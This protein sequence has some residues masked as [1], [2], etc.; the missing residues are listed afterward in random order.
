V[1][2]CHKETE[3]NESTVQVGLSQSAVMDTIG[4]ILFI[5]ISACAVGASLHAWRTRQA[6]G[7]SRFFALEAIALLVAINAG[8]WFQDPFSTRQIVSW[9]LIVIATALAVHGGY[10]LRDVG[11]AQERVI[12]DTLR[13]VDVGA[14]R[15]IRHPLYASLMLFAWGIFFKGID[16]ISAGL[17]FVVTAL[18]VVTG[19]YEERF[20][21][22]R[23][24]AAYE[25]YMQRT[26]MFVPFLL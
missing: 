10:L 22:E 21:V 18:L 20:N 11:R 25:E 9:T 16:L 1:I 7:F 4:L 8:H 14:Y 24:G 13:V 5:L 17:A 2:L 6:Y 15:F 3:G 23:L 12:E 19:R 26:K